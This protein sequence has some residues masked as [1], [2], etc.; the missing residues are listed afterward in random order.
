LTVFGFLFISPTITSLFRSIIHQKPLICIYKEGIRIRNV[1]PT[2]VFDFRCFFILKNFRRQTIQWEKIDTI[3][4]GRGILEIIGTSTDVDNQSRDKNN[5][6]VQVFSYD[7]N[8]F[9]IPV[10]KVGD[11]LCYFQHHSEKRQLLPNWKNQ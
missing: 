10:E 6:S 1:V 9:T 11:T 8:S 7:T 3:L 2:T 5:S 4:C